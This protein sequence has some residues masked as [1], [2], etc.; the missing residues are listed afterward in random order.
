[1]PLL[2]PMSGSGSLALEA[3]QIALRLPAGGQRGFAVNHLPCHREK[4]WLYLRAQALEEAGSRL[5]A[6][7]WIRDMDSLRPARENARLLGCNFNLDISGQINWQEENFF[8]APPPPGPGVVVINPP[9]GVRMGSLRQGEE[10]V[11]DLARSLGNNY[12]GWR[13]GIILYRPQWRRYFNLRDAV[14]RA[15][16]HGGLK[17]TMLSGVV[18]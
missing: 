18:V 1:M 9:Y 2:D 4:T 8:S 12:H 3:A 7:I 16:S 17:I 5:P 14:R 13:L 6:P 10:L 15:V 11:R